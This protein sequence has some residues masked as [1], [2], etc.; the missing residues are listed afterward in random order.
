MPKS[1]LARIVK[2]TINEQDTT[3]GLRITPDPRCVNIPNIVAIYGN[4]GSGKTSLSRYLSKLSGF[5]YLGADPIF[6]SHIAPCLANWEYFLAY[7]DLPNEHFSVS[8]YVESDFYDHNLFTT[9]L[10]E[11]L[12]RKLQF[13]PNTHTVLLDGYVFK[14]YTLIFPDLGLLPERTLALHAS[15]INGRYLVEGFDVTDG[16]YDAVLEHI[17]N[18][19][20]TKCSSITIPK[21]RYQSFKSLGLPSPAGA[22]SDSNTAEKYAASHLDEVVQATD[23]VIDIGC[24][25]GYFCFRIADKTH[26]TIIGVDM[27]R[28]WLEIASHLNN[29]I[30]LRDNIT[31]LNVGALEFLCANPNSFEIIHCASTYHYF[32]EHQVAFLREVHRALK[33]RGILVLEVELA[34]TDGEPEIVKRSRGVDSIPCAFP[35]RAMFMQQ[36]CGLFQVDNEFESTFQKGSFYSRVY[37]HLRP[38]QP[39]L[40]SVLDKTEG[41]SESERQ[42]SGS[43]S[44]LKFVLD[45]AEGRRISGWAMYPQLPHQKIKLLIKI[46][47]KKEFVVN[48][49]LF[50]RDLLAK[51]IHP[52][53][54]CGFGLT[55]QEEDILR[56]GDNISVLTFKESALDSVSVKSLTVKE[57]C[58]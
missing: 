48:A 25:T 53:G 16:R 56:P 35:N 38:V 58:F 43:S 3:G 32:R 2:S 17:Q 36:I 34:N 18:I 28:N 54:H 5:L 31:F 41:S 23:A 14:N 29:S 7:P 26:G 9:C 30:F 42:S 46:N 33:P 50:R 15:H 51:G 44:Q 21:S 13:S 20:L 8:R 10:K 45:K 6:S 52:T 12:R 22:N 39:Q 1:G 24:N 40:T 4:P 49:D 55:L 27:A 57:T 47:N 19:F 37:F 11:E